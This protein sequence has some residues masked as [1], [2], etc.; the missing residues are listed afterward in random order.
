VVVAVALPLYYSRQRVV[1]WFG[2]KNRSSK[3]SGS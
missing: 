1:A 2:G 3:D